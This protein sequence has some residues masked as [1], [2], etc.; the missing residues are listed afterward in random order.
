M[1]E[2]VQIVIYQDKEEC[3]QKSHSSGNNL[4]GYKKARPR[5]NN[6]QPTWQVINVQVPN[7]K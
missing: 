4:W 7:I 1:C 6:E 3:D 5:N 2:G